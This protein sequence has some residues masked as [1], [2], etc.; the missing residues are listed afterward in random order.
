MFLGILLLI[1]LG[2]IHGQ[3]NDIC[4]IRTREGHSNEQDTISQAHCAMYDRLHHNNQSTMQVIDLDGT[5]AGC[6]LYETEEEEVFYYNTNL[7]PSGMCSSPHYC[8][9]YTDCDS[10]VEGTETLYVAPTATPTSQAPTSDSQGN[11]IGVADLSEEP[12]S[13]PTREDPSTP[14]STILLVAVI[15]LVSLTSIA[16]FIATKTQTRTDVT[17]PS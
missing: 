2:I 8:I 3:T 1:I 7:N 14:T 6:W 4:V 15:T 12:T 10:A 16:G 5:I 9:H 13:A 17:Y 11:G